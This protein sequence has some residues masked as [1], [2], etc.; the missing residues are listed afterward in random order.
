MKKLITGA[1]AALTLGGAAL[2]TA[3]P[4]A[5]QWRGGGRYYGHSYHRGYNG[6]AVLGAGV[7]GLALG[8]AIA[9]NSRPYYYAPAPV[10]PAYGYYGPVC[11]SRL[12]WDPYW[13][14]YVRVEYCR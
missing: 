1:M 9:S 6:G 5:A 11:H 4:A 14:R 7:L 10:Y 3:T 8:A 2:A 12:R 13:G